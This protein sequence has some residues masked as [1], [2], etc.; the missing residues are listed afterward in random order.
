M[1][2]NVTHTQTRL[3]T[4]PARGAPCCRCTPSL[5]PCIIPFYFLSAVTARQPICVIK[6]TLKQFAANIFSLPIFFFFSQCTRV[7][8]GMS[9]N[10]TLTHTP[11]HTHTHT[12][13]HTCTHTCSY[14]HAHTHTHTHTLTHAQ[15]HLRTHTHNSVIRNGGPDRLSLLSRSFV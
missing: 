10:K 4:Q 13:T 8:S 1:C 14:K 11:T 9:R 2:F 6:M 3:P 12:H 7:R 5:G 15:T